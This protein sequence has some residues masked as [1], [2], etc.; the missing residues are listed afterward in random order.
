MKEVEKQTI[1]WK[2]S[3]HDEYLKWICGYANAYG[4]TLYI[5]KDD[6]GHPVSGVNTKELLTKIPDK[7]IS[8]MGIVPD[9]DVD[10]KDGISFI[11]IKVEKYPTMISYRGRYYYRTG[12]T[13]RELTGVE[14]DKRLL[15]AQGRSWDSVPVQDLTIRKLS[16]AAINLF[17]D[18]AVEQGRLSRQ[19]VNVS[20]AKLLE[21][22]HV[23]TRD[24]Q[25]TRA[26]MLAFHPDPE[27]W[28]TGSY[29]KIGFFGKSDADLQ[30]QDSVHG[31]LIEQVDKTMDLVYTK[32]MKAL[33]DYEGIQ[34]IEQF[35]FPYEAFRE[36][37]INAVVHKDYSSCNPI[38]ISIYENQIYIWNNAEMPDTLSSAKKLYQKHTSIP[39]NPQLA[40][41]FFKSGM[42]EA[43]GRSFEK[44]REACAEYDNAPLPKLDISEDGVMVHCLPCKRYV[45]LLKQNDNSLISNGRIMSGLMSGKTGDRLRV[46]LNYLNSHDTINT[47]I[48]ANIT[49]KSESQ[50]KRYLGALEKAGQIRRTKTTKGNAYVRI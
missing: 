23:L 50:A 37:L 27:R 2:E 9:V 8:T 38:Q 30:Y 21:K 48:A 5:G 31:P 6:D 20:D 44:I 47:E 14:L 34:R 28:I 15:Q 10:E 32:Y 16:H 39:Y 35:M 33:I 11:V 17:R 49:G 26:A 24:G 13:M 18:K 1:E 45:R 7:V 4:G 40:E 36:L 29:I 19:D 3:W 42:I 25:P 22:L 41:V 12:S 46:I 43:W